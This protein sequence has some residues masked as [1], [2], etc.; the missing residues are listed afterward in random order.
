MINYSTHTL[1]N[2]LRIIHHHDATTRMVALNLLYN[3]GSK[4]E[5]PNKTG[6]AHLMEHLMFAGSKNAPDYDAPLQAAGGTNNAWTNE[7]VT[8]YYDI[9][10][11]QNIETAFWLESDRLLHLQLSEE[12]VQIQKSVVCEEFKQQHLNQPYGDVPH[13]VRSLAF[14]SHPYH[15]PV[16]GKELGHI[17][18][19]SRDDVVDFYQKHYSASNLIMCVSGNISLDKTLALA[20]KW[21]GDIPSRAVE[22][23]VITPEPPQAEY[24]SARIVKPCPNNM[25]VR[26]Y[27][28]PGRYTKEYKHCD[29]LTDVLAN[30][31]ASRFYRN[32]LVKS[33]AFSVLDA[34]VNCL[35]DSSLL[36]VKAKLNRGVAFE[37]AEEL[38]DAE[39]NSYFR[40]GSSREEIQRHVNKY[41][42]RDSYENGGYGEIAE[43][44]CLFHSVGKVHEINTEYDDYSAI[45]PDDVMAAART[46]L[47]PDNCS[48][49]FYGSEN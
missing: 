19:M 22:K 30:G 15:W 4:N 44:L 45:T 41:I 28:I 12:N 25:I 35:T 7:D 26:A 46:Y 40:E 36:I 33:G 9:V 47:T 38:I 43:K 17:E 42:T 24:R 23:R 14:T 29:L 11:A 5:C 49:I 34:S 16:I 48:T 27:H 39:L 18:N 6:L 21:F 2:G 32:V 8:N 31:N 13:L 37:K 20:E 10:P 1:A 3:V